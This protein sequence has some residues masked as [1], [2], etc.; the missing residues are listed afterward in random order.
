MSNNS[1]HL[2]DLSRNSCVGAEQEDDFVF[3][4]RPDTAMDWDIVDAQSNDAED[5]CQDSGFGGGQSCGELNAEPEMEKNNEFWTTCETCRVASWNN[6]VQCCNNED[7][8]WITEMETDL[9]DLSIH[10]GLWHAT[11][12]VNTPSPA[13]DPNH[14]YSEL[15]GATEGAKS[16]ATRPSIPLFFLE[17]CELDNAQPFYAGNDVMHT[18]Q[19]ATK[20][21]SPSPS[22]IPR[23]MKTISLSSNTDVSSN[24]LGESKTCLYSYF[25]GHRAL[26]WALPPPSGGRATYRRCEA[27]F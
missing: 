17:K 9:D 15:L 10:S 14:E 1:L 3:F 11:K 7:G 20:D 6:G 26:R 12:C 21:K 22:R 13:A 25:A 23:L 8:T 4:D 5:I 16:T 19:A 27:C 24:I 18:E 2:V